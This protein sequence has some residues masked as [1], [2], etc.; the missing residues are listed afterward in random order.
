MIAG[1]EYD[2]KSADTWSCGVI[3]FAMVNGYLPFED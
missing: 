2:P 3:L 1:K